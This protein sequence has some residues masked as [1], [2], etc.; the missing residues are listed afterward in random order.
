M[1]NRAVIVRLSAKEREMYE[2]NKLLIQGDHEVLIRVFPKTL[3]IYL[4]HNGSPDCIYPLLQYA[5]LRHMKPRQTSGV[6]V[7]WD[8]DRCTLDMLLVILRNWVGNDAECPF[9]HLLERLDLDNGDNG[10]YLVDDSFNLIDRL[11]LKGYEEEVWEAQVQYEQGNIV[12]MLTI[13]KQNKVLTL[14][15]EG[16]WE[17]NFAE[18]ERFEKYLIERQQAVQEKEE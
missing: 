14:D 1:G 4:H 5:Q 13:H 11:Y 18:W 7:G 9:M 16:G 10:T 6:I 17:R 15:T 2:Q 3:G 8:M 12:T